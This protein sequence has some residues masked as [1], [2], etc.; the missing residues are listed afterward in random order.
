MQFPTKLLILIALICISEIS[1]KSHHNRSK[2][3]AKQDSWENG[4][5]CPK[6]RVRLATDDKSKSVD[7][8]ME[9]INLNGSQILSPIDD[10]ERAG[11]IFEIPPSQKPTG[12]FQDLLVNHPDPSRKNSYILPY[13]KISSDFYS[14]KRGVKK[15]WIFGG[16]RHV[17]LYG[18][19]MGHSNG[20]AQKYRIKI[21]LPYEGNLTKVS[22]SEISRILYGINTHRM[23][24]HE[25][26]FNLKS[27][28]MKALNAYKRNREI[29]DDL[30]RTHGDIPALRIKYKE[31][32]LH[33]TKKFYG[34]A[35]ASAI[36]LSQMIT[37]KE[38]RGKLSA[39]I[40]QLSNK[41]NSES[42]Q[43]DEIEGEIESVKKAS[44]NH[45]KLQAE[46]TEKKEKS[47]NGL[48]KL[49]SEIT[50]LDSDL[51]SFTN[52]LIE[53][54]KNNPAFSVDSS[55]FTQKMTSL[56]PY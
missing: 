19:A 18:F 46:F 50:Q 7:Q 13:T 12:Y 29:L 17:V 5:T 42:K 41:V 28:M 49:L 21:T 51:H 2:S 53:G 36:F 20:T 48:I 55:V 15:V 32:L 11:I 10:N 4:F 37:L 44:E 47:R 6:I 3:H 14:M 45:A 38:E 22:E 23:E 52:P 33:T 56:I 40:F 25:T 26:I 39:Q 54:I 1:P 30:T 27:N 34:K 35:I 8:I 24:I 9:N 16:G 43:M 31:K